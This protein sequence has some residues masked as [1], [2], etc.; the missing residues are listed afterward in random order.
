[1]ARPTK[2]RSVE[3]IPTETKFIPEGSSN[4]NIHFNEIKIEELEA[5]RLKDLADVVLTT[6]DQSEIA[7]LDGKE[8]VMIVIE[9][10]TDGNYMLKKIHEIK[11]QVENCAN[12]SAF[13]NCCH[14]QRMYFK[15]LKRLMFIAEIF[16]YNIY[17]CYY[18]KFHLHHQ[19]LKC[20]LL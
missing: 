1:M 19:M 11:F 3:F 7:K 8:S 10:S 16:L 12:C 17:T 2:V 20:D 5:L 15:V 14:I 18:C 6:E 4:C 13:Q 9:K